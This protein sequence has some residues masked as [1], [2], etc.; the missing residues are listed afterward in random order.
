M[1]KHNNVNPDHYKL[2]GR[3]RPGKGMIEA[4][5]R[6]EYESTPRPARDKAREPHIPNQ[7]RASR[8]TTS[9]RAEKP[10]TGTQLTDDEG[11]VD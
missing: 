9:G 3:E 8:P 5:E 2:R 11:M 4:N 1:S 6:Q 7:E 10:D